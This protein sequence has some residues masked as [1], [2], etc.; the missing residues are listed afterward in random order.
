MKEF[1]RLLKY[2]RPHLLTFALA[3]TAMIFVA[4]F[5]SA[6][7]ALLVPIFDQFLPS[8]AKNSD[9]FVRSAKIDSAKRL[10]SGVDNDFDFAD[11]VHDSQRRCRIFFFIF[12]GENRAVNSA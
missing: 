2:L 12:N 4:V 5:E 9:D 6:T 7:L 10:V 11:F 8:A 1:K 3:I